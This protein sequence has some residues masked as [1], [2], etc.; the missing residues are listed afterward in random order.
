MGQLIEDTRSGLQH[1]HSFFI[2]HVKRDANQVPNRLAKLAISQLLDT[3]W[4]EC[5]SFSQDVTLTEQ[6]L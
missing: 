5:S 1:F 2:K 4:I 6:E 3:S